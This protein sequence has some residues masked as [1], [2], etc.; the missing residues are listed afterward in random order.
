M[1]AADNNQQYVHPPVLVAAMVAF[2]A[3]E[4]AEM[5]EVAVNTAGGAKSGL[6][7]QMWQQKLQMELQGRPQ[8]LQEAGSAAIGSAEITGCDLICTNDLEG[9]V[10]SVAVVRGLVIVEDGD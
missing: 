4:G 8:D 1:T 10:W 2:D 3:A 5:A 7:L 6:K 9:L